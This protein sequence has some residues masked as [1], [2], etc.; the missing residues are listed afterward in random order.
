MNVNIIETKKFSKTSLGVGNFDFL[1]EGK[2][3]YQ[4]PSVKFPVKNKPGNNECFDKSFTKPSNTNKRKK[5]KS[6]K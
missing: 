4:N 6:K 2:C 3:M 5:K 1:K